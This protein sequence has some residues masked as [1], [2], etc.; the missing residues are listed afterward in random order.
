MLLAAVILPLSASL[1]TAAVVGDSARYNRT[2][3]V[4][5]TDGTDSDGCVEHPGPDNACKSLDFVFQPHYREN[6]T[7]YTL[8]PGTHHINFTATFAGISDLAI[9]G[10]SSDEHSVKITCVAKNSGFSFLDAKNVAFSNLSLTGCASPQ[11]GTSR[12]TL[13]SK[14]EL[15]LV[16]TALYFS[17]CE[18]IAL[19]N[20]MVSESPAASGVTVY[21]TIG[22]NTFTWCKFFSNTGSMHPSYSSGGGVYIEFSYCAPGDISCVSANKSSYTDFNS[23]STYI[24]TD[25]IFENNFATLSASDNIVYFFLRQQNHVSFGQGGG[26]SVFFC[27]N[28]TDNSFRVKNC[29]FSGNNATLGGGLFVEFSD[30]SEK[31]FVSIAGSNFTNNICTAYGRGGGVNINQFAL[32]TNRPLAGNSVNLA[33]CVFTKNRAIKGGGLRVII[34]SH[35]PFNFSLLNVNFSHNLGQ[36]GAAIIVEVSEI[37]LEGHMPLLYI[38]NCL[39]Y[40][41]SVRQAYTGPYEVGLG[42]VYI[43]K[44]SVQFSKVNQFVENFGSALVVVGATV[45]ISSANLTFFRNEGVN[46]GALSLIG[47]SKLLIDNSTYVMFLSNFALVAGGAIFNK[48]TEGNTYQYITNCFIVHKSGVLDPNKWEAYFIFYDNYDSTGRNSIYSTS[49]LSCDSTEKMNMSQVFCWENWIYMYGSWAEQNCSKFIRTAPG[50]IKVNVNTSTDKGFVI[51]AYPGEIREIPISIFGDL[52]HTATAIFSTNWTLL[53][54]AAS[55]DP[56]YTFVSSSTVRVLGSP[57]G[58]INIYLNSIGDRSWDIRFV[59]NLTECPPGLMTQPALNRSSSSLNQDR[60]KSERDGFGIDDSVANTSA[61]ACMSPQGVIQYLRCNSATNVSLL[62]GYWMGEEMYNGEHTYLISPCPS[63]FCLATNHEYNPLPRDNLNEHICGPHKRRG[64]VCGECIAGHGHA[65]NSD[66]F[67]C[68]SCTLSR[69]QLAQHITYYILS[70]Y[71]P[72]FLLFLAIIVFNIKLTTGPA[73][74][75]ILYSQ[76]ISS[77][78][79]IN[80]DNRIPLTSISPQIASYMKAYRFP[81]GIFNLEFFEIFVPTKYMCLGTQLNVMDILLL[82]YLVAFFPLLM[83]VAIFVAYRVTGRCTRCPGCSHRFCWARVV[84]YLSWNTSK[85]KFEGSSDRLR[86]A[87]VPAFASFILLSYTKFSLTSSLI[88]APAKLHTLSGK[89]TTSAYLYYAS[90]LTYSD[91]TNIFKYILPAIFVLATFVAIPPLFLLDYPLR[92]LER[93]LRACPLLRRFYPS[94]KVHI[95]LDAFQGCYRDQCRWFAGLYFVFRLIINITNAFFEDLRQFVLQEVYCVVFALLVA[96]LRPYRQQYYLLNYFDSFIFLNLAAINLIS[97]YLYADT[98]RGSEPSAPVFW[99]QYS[100]VCLPLV[101]MCGYILW[102]LLPP[103]RLRGRV[104]EW[105]EARH[106]LR[107]ME[108]L[109]QNNREETSVADE[110]GVDWER[111]QAVNRYKA[112]VSPEGPLH[113][114]IPPPDR[115]TSVDTDTAGSETISTGLKRGKVCEGEGYGSTSDSGIAVVGRASIN[116]SVTG[117]STSISLVASS[118]DE[119]ND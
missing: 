113:S 106:S 92:L 65:I 102:C 26:L 76:V 71:L 84:Q 3:Y 108:S 86:K 109:V 112:A 33:D 83:I 117:G 90:Q 54:G 11:N 17:H 9:A 10:N 22:T 68:V 28:A 75:F 20:V 69:R 67:E 56:D 6:S 46:G 48:Y 32:P 70:V 15:S 61:C 82:E 59:V 36:Y 101:Y 45:D 51:S 110:D 43:E 18:N 38:E 100:L 99:I 24:F 73:N 115:L 53:A 105:L 1:A 60:G 74:A 2:I 47:L 80:A 104:R 89:Q 107:Q 78:L 13:S 63:G 19:E 55:L 119:E 44:V 4:D 87:M 81:Y 16:Y 27:G 12:S 66:N 31:N 57:N 58:S 114:S 79:N 8:Q 103:P 62:N 35:S 72:L 111:A 41:N 52:N 30:T 25:C 29:S 95:I 40:K 96:F 14:F 116:R 23:N 91:P 85:E 37:S 97:L 50:N 5:P 98:R 77:T 21:N 64:R 42:A 118:S 49:V 7:R 94:D 88:L 93:V 34:T 39:F